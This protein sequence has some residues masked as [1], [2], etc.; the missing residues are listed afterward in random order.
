MP[1]KEKHC[2]AFFFQ[3]SPLSEPFTGDKSRAPSVA[4][5]RDC[6]FNS[7]ETWLTEWPANTLF[8]SQFITFKRRDADT[9]M[10]SLTRHLLISYVSRDLRSSNREKCSN[11]AIFATSRMRRD[12]KAP[13]EIVMCVRFT[14][15][16]TGPVREL[17]FDVFQG[18]AYILASHFL[19]WQLT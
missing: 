14:R 2:E 17:S 7:S 3:V 12:F 13:L 9:R 8:T 6:Q 15:V 4:V 18:K 1:L 10:I 16:Y 19:P 11:K 5:K